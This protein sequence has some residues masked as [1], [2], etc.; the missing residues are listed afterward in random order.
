MADHEVLEFDD[1]QPHLLLKN[2]NFLYK[3]PYRD[4]WAVLKVYYGSRNHWQNVQKSIE[5]VSAGQTS[6]M[7]KTRLKVERECLDVWRRHGFRVFGTYDDVE[8]RAPQCPEGGYMLFEYVDA[9]KL[10]A[11]LRDTERPLE[12]RLE[13]F[14]RFLKEWGRRHEIAIRER[15]PRLVHE[16][17]DGKHVLIMEDGSLLWFDF[18]MIYRSRRKVP[19][20]VCHEIIQYIWYLNRNSSPDFQERLLEETATHYP[21]R[22]RLYAAYEY[23][24]RHPNPLHR[25]GRALERHFKKSRGEAKSKYGVARRLKEQLDAL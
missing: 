23:F 11:C 5:N 18:E 21:S 25:W 24:F 22:E 4:S 3:I 16:N 1:L 7:P 9:P 19:L 12:E 10:D 20:H 2:G 15:E 17:G 8:V 14:R 6:Y 13:L